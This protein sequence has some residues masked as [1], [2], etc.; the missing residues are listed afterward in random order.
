MNARQQARKRSLPK[1]TPAKFG[2]LNAALQAEKVLIRDLEDALI[3][4]TARTR[5]LDEI[6]QIGESE[7]TR[8]YPALN[9]DGA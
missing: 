8:K 7:L 2:R 9:K 5:A 1:H 6:T 4:T 3:E